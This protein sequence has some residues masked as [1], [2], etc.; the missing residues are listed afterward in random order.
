MAQLDGA[1][2]KAQKGQGGDVKKKSGGRGK[3][4]ENGGLECASAAPQV[5]S[6]QWKA[7]DQ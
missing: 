4:L 6:A 7:W 1:E 5:V 3:R 2:T